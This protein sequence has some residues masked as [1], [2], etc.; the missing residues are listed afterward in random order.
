MPMTLRGQAAISI[1]T[2]NAKALEVH[3]SENAA[4]IVMALIEFLRP[5]LDSKTPADDCQSQGDGDGSVCDESQPSSICGEHF[6]VEAKG[7]V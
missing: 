7:Q 5:V 1:D 3:G 6:N 4:Q 2:L